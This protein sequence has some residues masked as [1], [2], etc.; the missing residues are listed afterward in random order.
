MS[1]RRAVL[2]VPFGG[3]CVRAL[4]SAVCVSVRVTD[5]SEAQASGA[6]GLPRGFALLGLLRCEPRC[7]A[8]TFAPPLY[9]VR[10]RG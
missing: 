1:E 9:P 3:G 8:R 5:R 2:L 6:C 4:R 7:R 10:R